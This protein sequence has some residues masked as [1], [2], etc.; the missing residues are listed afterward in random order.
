M[1][2]IVL[3]VAVCV[4]AFAA[5]AL[6]AEKGAGGTAVVTFVH[7]ER[8]HDIKLTNES[9]ADSRAILLPDLEK[10]IKD[11][12]AKHLRDGDRLDVKVLDIQDTGL[13]KS[14]NK[15]RVTQQGRGAI[16]ARME[17]EYT[18]T[19]ASGAAIRSGRQT[20]TRM[21]EDFDD[22]LSN[23]QRAPELKYMLRDWIRGLGKR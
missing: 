22:T 21:P 10:Y 2:T 20:L 23:Y 13:V 11:Q 19:D 4:A 17:V 7:P 6:A 12:A 3:S 8:Y 15:P 9:Q 1:K 14:R 16:P 18:L 5:F